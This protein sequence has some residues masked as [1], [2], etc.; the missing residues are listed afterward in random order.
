MFLGRAAELKMLE[1]QHR[2]PR[3][4]FV[5]I[6]GRR[7]VGKSELIVKFLGDKPAL[8]HV[9]KTAPGPLQLREL[10]DQAATVLDEPLLRHLPLDDWRGALEQLTQRARGQKL[11]LAL[12]EFQ[13]LVHAVPEL[14]SLLQEL[15]DARWSKSNAL[16][17]I[18]CGSYVGFM[19]REV[20]GKKSPLF[21]RRTAQLR[22]GPFPYWQARAFHPR[23]S[24]A[25]QAG[26]YFLCG[27]VPQYLKAFDPKR[28]L[29]ANIE[30]ALLDEFAPLFREPEFL[31]REELRE[32][33]GYYAVLLAVAEGMGDLAS[34]AARSAI[35]ERSLPY[36]LQQ[37]LEL[38]YLGRR[39]PLTSDKPARRQ[40]RY[41]VDDPLL[42]FWFRF[43]FPNLSFLQQMGPEKTFRERIKPEL[44]A[45]FGGCFERLCRE[46]L[47]LLY[48]S[49]GVSAAFETGEYWDKRVQVDVIGLREDHW[50]DLAECK[51]GQ[52]RSA[53]N[54]EEEL[55]A[56]VPLYPNR[57]NA[58]L[59]LRVFSQQRVKGSGGAVQWTS[60]E[61]LYA[62]GEE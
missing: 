33:D 26:A 54:V 40:V 39:Y 7:R 25:D 28:S 43:V 45:Y 59:G 61:D 57:R 4:A 17:L 50:T 55:L 31:L 53:R 62:L 60:L 58:T 10:L 41:V 1:A 20:L 11:V 24:P 38:G 35:P 22:L 29:Q 13:W 9:G 52:V 23:W 5:P 8:Y 42:R 48:A 16:T 36:Y 34:I 14:P 56:K 47:P 32:I 18:L 37:L 49:E 51:W 15:W 30:S 44:P 27:G 3:S 2:S 6:Y 19:E 12:D 46:A 21:G